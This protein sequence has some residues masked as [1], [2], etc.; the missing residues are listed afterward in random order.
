M[1]KNNMSR[2]SFASFHL[3]GIKQT[4]RSI[5]ATSV[6]RLF[7]GE[8]NGTASVNIN[9]GEFD[10]SILRIKLNTLSNLSHFAESSLD[11]RMCNAKTEWFTRE[12]E[13]HRQDKFMWAGQSRNR[14]FDSK[15]FTK[16]FFEWNQ[17]TASGNCVGK[18]TSTQWENSR[19]T[20]FINRESKWCKDVGCMFANLIDFNDEWF[21]SLLF[22]DHQNQI[23][24]L[25]HAWKVNYS[26]SSTSKSWL[27]KKCEYQ[28]SIIIQITGCHSF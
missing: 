22:L 5:M 16:R 10:V 18:S 1:E 24:S 4:S 12:W 15:E 19:C 8:T 9:H 6:D 2:S 3:T 14:Y 21:V 23:P 17:T 25:P 13:I 11:S 7:S 27:K 28:A 20:T 26:K